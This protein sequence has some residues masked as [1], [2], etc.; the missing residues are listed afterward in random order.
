MRLRYAASI[1]VLLPA[2]AAPAPA[3]SDEAVARRQMESAIALQ[4]AGRYGEAVQQLSQAIAGGALVPADLARAYYDRGVAQ[5]G[6]GNLTAA[7]ADY[8]EAIQRDPA[9]APAYN[10][11]ANVWR[12]TGRIADAKRDYHTALNCPGAAREY[13]LFGLGLIARAEGDE[14]AAADFFRKALEANPAF[15]PATQAL[16]ALRPPPQRS[17]DQI[18]APTGA[19]PEVPSDS[20]VLVQLGAF[21]SEALARDAWPAIAARDGALRGQVPIIVPADVPAKGR[22]WRLR[23]AAA[24]KKEAQALCAALARQKQACIVVRP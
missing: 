16:T 7:V 12:R 1:L 23:A 14:S 8:D 18:N 24:G 2:L 3:P 17:N 21:G 15:A 9:L 22:F 10:N 13:S 5:D 20:G 11:R 19:K 4:A 6:A